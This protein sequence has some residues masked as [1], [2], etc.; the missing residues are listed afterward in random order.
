[1]SNVDKISLLNAILVNENIR[2]AMLV[3]PADNDES[4]GEDPKTKS[5][6]NAIKTEFPELLQSGNYETYQ[7]I[8]IS[9]VDYN[10]KTDISL[11][12]MGQIL[13]YPCYTDFNTINPNDTSFSITVYAYI[14]NGRK[15]PLLANQCKDETKKDI[16]KQFAVKASE[17]FAMEKYKK[18]LESIEIDKIDVEIVKTVSTQSIIDKLIE[19]E[20]LDKY[21]TDKILNILF[22]SGFSM[23][24]QFY[25]IDKFQYNNPIHKGILLDLLVREN[26]NI[27]SP[28]FPLQ[29]YPEQ[30]KELAVIIE[31]LEKDL[32]DL[33]EKTKLNMKKIYGNGRSRKT[34]K[35]IHG[36][37]RSRKTTKK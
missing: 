28:F 17:V 7:G 25:F 34:T 8:I 37:G 1:M 30:D 35:K 36:N 21:D 12:D 31:S 16:F 15:I 19:N 11:E 2:P 29:E 26:H 10:G 5:I 33:L 14:K 32:I 13:G 6:L 24:L 4:T 3:Q 27:L 9:K 22:N 23:E 20:N 18:K